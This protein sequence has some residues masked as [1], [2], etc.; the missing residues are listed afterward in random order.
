MIASLYQSG[1]A[2][3]PCDCVMRL[4]LGA[5]MAHGKLSMS[6]SLANKTPCPRK[7]DARSSSLRSHSEPSFAQNYF[8]ET[9]DLNA[10]LES[11]GRIPSHRLRHPNGRPASD[12]F[13]LSNFCLRRLNLIFCMHRKTKKQERRKGKRQKRRFSAPPQLE[14]G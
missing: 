9:T 2:F 4:T 3:S 13:L 5:Q 14:P 1:S 12:P 6:Q 8:C 10:L 11:V 7:R